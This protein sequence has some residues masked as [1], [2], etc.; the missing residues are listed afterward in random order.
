MSYHKNLMRLINN[1]INSATKMAEQ[2]NIYENV[3][4]VE[5][6]D[7]VIK[8]CTERYSKVDEKF[9]SKK[10]SRLEI[11]QEL[12]RMFKTIHAEIYYHAFDHQNEKL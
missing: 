5:L 4:P 6:S 3:H 11:H 7:Y 9:R 8:L 1:S 12:K 2:F 10:P